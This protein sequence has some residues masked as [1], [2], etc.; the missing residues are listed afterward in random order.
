MVWLGEE[1][2]AKKTH[3]SDLQDAFWRAIMSGKRSRGEGTITFDKRRKRYRARVTVGWEFD[4]ETG[5]TKQIVKTLGSNYKTKGEASA[6]L[7]AYL[8]TPYDLDNKDITFSQLYEKWFDDF[9]AE[10]ESHK[11]RIKSAYQYC[12]SIYN[13]KFREIS[14]LELGQVIYLPFYFRCA[15]IISVNYLTLA[16]VISEITIIL[17][18][19]DL[20]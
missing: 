8:H 1:K 6:A 20:F 15:R 19:A 4:E 3:F 9:V 10:H 14:I 7:A 16:I 17:K 12:T 5:R 18:D 11:Y 13:K 2:D